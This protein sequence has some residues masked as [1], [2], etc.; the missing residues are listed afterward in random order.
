MKSAEVS[1]KKTSLKPSQS[2]GGAAT[3]DK[4]LSAAIQIIIT[5]GIERL[6]LDAVAREAVVSKGGLLY[7]FPSKEALIAGVITYLIDDFNAAIEKELI[8]SNTDN[9]SKDW[10]KAYVRASF[11]SSQP[12][13]ALIAGLFIAVTHNPE[14]VE[15][16]RVGCAEWQR[17]FD[18]SGLD[19]VQAGI[20][21]L[22]TEGLYPTEM[23]GVEP[24]TEPLRSQLKD[25]I[26]A[27]I[28]SSN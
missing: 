14:L 15:H 11:N 22:A 2:K 16:A 9:P 4:L 10:L 24:I 18:E 17:H 23:F 28:D 5:Q 25:A 26:L 12:P 13:L 19:P 21:R 8:H 3:R 6:T 27:L 1:T 7:H 20:I